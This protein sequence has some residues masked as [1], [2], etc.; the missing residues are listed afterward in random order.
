MLSYLKYLPESG[1][2]KHMFLFLHGLGA[3]ADDLKGFVDVFKP[4]CK[5]TAFIIP[6]ATYPCRGYP[7][8]EWFNA[9][10]REP[11]ILE[12]NMH[13]NLHHLDNFITKILNEYNL[14]ESS[15]SVLGFSQGSAMALNVLPRRKKACNAILS[16]SGGIL[17][18]NFFAKEFKSK[19]Q[20]FLAHGDVDE[21]VPLSSLELSAEILKSL[22]FDFI[23]NKIKGM[24]HYIS[25]EAIKMA[26]NFLQETRFFNRLKLSPQI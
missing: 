11:R 6:N 25:Q 23:A 22:D 4:I 7:G 1:K 8:Y 16:F 9:D 18:G 17:G 19:P 21:V 5:D 2:I 26:E 3:S 10:I 24:G 15:L 13:E 20:I 12:K 14:D